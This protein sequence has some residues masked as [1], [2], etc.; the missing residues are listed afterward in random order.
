[1][2]NVKWK[3]YIIHF[4]ERKKVYTIVVVIIWGKFMCDVEYNIY[5]IYI[6]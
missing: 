4:M 2:D 5:I 6:V 3:A 1:M